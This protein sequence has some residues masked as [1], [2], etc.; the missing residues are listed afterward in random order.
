MVGPPLSPRL[1]VRV[2]SALI[3]TFSASAVMASAESWVWR[4]PGA[5]NMGQGGPR[6]KGPSKRT[7]LYF[8][9]AW[10]LVTLT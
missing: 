6:P 8:A 10:D 5:E 2:P 7:P 9:K 1:K 3:P 4:G